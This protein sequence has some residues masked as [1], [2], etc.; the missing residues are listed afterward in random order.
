MPALPGL[1]VVLLEMG[2]DPRH[3]ACTPLQQRLG[4]LVLEFTSAP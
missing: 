3:S 2:F 4:Y 1:C